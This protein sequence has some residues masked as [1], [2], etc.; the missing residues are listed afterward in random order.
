MNTLP[1]KSH[2]SP[3]F[4]LIE[5]LITLV[6]IAIGLLGLAGLQVFSLQSQL[7][8]YQRAQAVMLAEEMVNRIRVNAPAA[9]AGAYTPGVEYGLLTPAVCDP[10]TQTTAEYDLCDWNNILAGQDVLAGGVNAGSVNA[11]RGCIE[12]VVGSID[13]ETRILVTVAWQ[14]AVATASPDL[15]C[16][17]NAYGDNDAFRRVVAI[18]AVLADLV[19]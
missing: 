3:G 10:A 16:G 15:D 7:E 18:E 19:N 9:R 12:N 2:G 13:G 6:I 8:A 4:T 1:I 17:F 11:A 5:V 14:G